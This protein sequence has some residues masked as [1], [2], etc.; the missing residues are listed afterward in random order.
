MKMYLIVAAL[1]GAVGYGLW[2]YYQYTQ[3]QIRV[4][5]T[6]AATA[7]QAQEAS[8]AALVQ[9]QIDLQE[10]QEQFNIVSEKFNAAQERV[11]DLEEKLSKHE[12]G[13]LAENKP[14]LVEKVVDNGTKDVLRCFE[15][16]SGSPL[17]EDELNATKKSQVNT[18]CSDIANPNYIPN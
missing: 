11:N 3:E 13:M 15:I 16:M 7:Q 10:V 1:L 4:Y 17:T 12:I 14:G 9:V 6:N 5:A 8:E 2:A 18:S